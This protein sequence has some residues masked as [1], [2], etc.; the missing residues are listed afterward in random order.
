MQSAITNWNGKLTF[1]G[2]EA[3]E[4]DS[5]GVAVPK[6]LPV[7]FQAQPV[8]TEAESANATVIIHPATVIGGSTGNPIDAGN[9]YEERN[10]AMYPADESMIYAHE[11][12]HL[13]G[14]P[15]EYSQS[16]RQMHLLLHQAS[17]SSAVAAGAALDRAT[18][19]RMVL[20]AMSNPLYAQMTA[21]MPAVVSAFRGAQPLVTTKMSAALRQGIRDESVSSALETRLEQSSADRLHA[22]VPHIAAFQ[23]TANFSPRSRAIDGVGAEFAGPALTTRIQDSYWR[24]LQ[25]PLGANVAV[26]GL[27]DV[28]INLSSGVAGMGQGTGPVATPAGALATTTVGAAAAPGSRIPPIAPPASLVGQLRA[29][30]ATWDAAGSVV[31]SAITP[32]AVAARMSA[33]LTAANVAAMIAPV[34]PGVVAAP[35]TQQV[36]ALYRQALQIVTNLSST[37]ARQI[38]ADLLSSQLTPVLQ[39]SVTSFQ[40]A[41]RTEVDRIMTTPA[42]A[43]AATGTPD[44]DLVAVVAGMKARLD[45]AKAA[46]ASTTSRDPIGAGQAAPDQDVTY[47]YQ[48]LMGTNATAALRTDQFAPM[49]LQFNANFKRPREADFTAE[50]R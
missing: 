35:R 45:A 27:G 4:G 14:I 11:Y 22:S 40:T 34:V 25:A 23:T 5:A 26:E 2:S 32:E 42:G 15:D 21:A 16:N 43:L 49:V 1:V 19:E 7:T 29:I 48:G 3:P 12:G 33:T 36:G 50:S 24:A 9:F 18:V 10:R 28:S 41:I 20:S 38:V 30:P 44:P 39:A 31:E 17:P 6:R 8:W 46:T 47:S 13:L 37:V